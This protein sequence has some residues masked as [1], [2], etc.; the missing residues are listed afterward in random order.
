VQD[1]IRGLEC[2]IERMQA[3]LDPSQRRA[4][5][6]TFVAECE[7]QFKSL[8]TLFYDF[9]VRRDPNDSWDLP[10][11]RDFEDALDVAIQAREATILARIPLTT[12][13]E[14]VIDSIRQAKRHGHMVWVAG[15]ER[16]GK[17]TGAE[18]YAKARPDLVKLV[19][20]VA[21]SDDRVFYETFAA[22]VG[23]SIEHAEKLGSLKRKIVTA[24]R[25]ADQVLVI[26][27][28]HALFG[29]GQRPTAKRAD[30]LRTALLNLRVPTVLIFTGMQFADRLNELRKR[31]EWN[32]RQFEGRRGAF[33]WVDEPSWDEMLTV[34]RHYLPTASE[35]GVEIA[36]AASWHQQHRLPALIRIAN[37]AAEKAREAGVADPSDEHLKHAA[38]IVLGTENLIQRHGLGDPETPR[39]KR[40]SAP[41]MPS[42]Q[43]DEEEPAEAPASEPLPARSRTT[44]EP[45]QTGFN[46]IA[47]TVQRGLETAATAP[48]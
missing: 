35:A 3:K 8:P 15:D 16:I 7:K 14:A 32:C 19:P 43:V 17:T 9:V 20:L 2:A 13:N 28:A 33:Y 37:E 24:L 42:P 5:A 39:K 22:G 41:A 6:S 10:C 31:S 45:V 21:D 1:K 18:A 12:T 23:C 48:G 11:F 34:A 4:P 38:G 44:S 25:N 26:D 40:T 36:V 46:R 30:W 47:R 27:E 29:A